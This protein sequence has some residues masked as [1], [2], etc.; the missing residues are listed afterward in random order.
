MRLRAL[1]PSSSSE[2]EVV[3]FNERKRTI[4]FPMRDHLPGGQINDTIQTKNTTP[5]LGNKGHGL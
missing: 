5:S 4:P 3:V 2:T 1:R